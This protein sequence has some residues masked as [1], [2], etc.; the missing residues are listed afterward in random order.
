M[1]AFTKHLRNDGHTRRYTIAMTSGGW[2]VLEEED[3]R[4]VRRVEYQDWHRVE[5]ARRIITIHTDQLQDAG[6]RLE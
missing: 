1:H 6:W 2:E 4:V 3:S 5:R